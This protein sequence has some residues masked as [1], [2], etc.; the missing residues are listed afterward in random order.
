VQRESSERLIFDFGVYC[1]YDPKTSGLRELPLKMPPLARK[2]TASCLPVAGVEVVPLVAGA[3]PIV[4][5]GPVVGLVVGVLCLLVVEASS[6]LVITSLG[7]E[8]RSLLLLKPTCPLASAINMI[9]HKTLHSPQTL[10]Q[11]ERLPAETVSDH[12]LPA[13]TLTS[14]DNRSI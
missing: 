12:H 14:F 11:Q 8:G 6:L 10:N 9:F 1:V 3:A 13:H 4:V 2:E 7:V 5:R